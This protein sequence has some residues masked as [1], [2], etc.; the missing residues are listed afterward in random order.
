MSQQSFR[1]SRLQLSL[2]HPR[3]ITPTPASFE[4]TVP[5]ESRL[6]SPSPDVHSKRVIALFCFFE[7]V[8]V[9]RRKYAW[10][11]TWKH[12]SHHENGNRT[13]MYSQWGAC[14]I[15]TWAIYNLWKTKLCASRLW[16]WEIFYFKFLVI[17]QLTIHELYSYGILADFVE[18]PP[19]CILVTETFNYT[20]VYERKTKGKSM[21]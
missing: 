5:V 20:G 15:S 12:R 8:C 4:A 11:K 2:S 14:R 3:G 18:C 16:T 9:A 13:L 6:S 10:N 21:I 1:E 17:K 19:A 7:H